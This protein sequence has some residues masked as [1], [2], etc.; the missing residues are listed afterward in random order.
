MNCCVECFEDINVIKL[1]ESKQILNKKCDYCDSEDVL[2]AD[3]RDLSDMFNRLFTYYKET[4]PFEHYF[5]EEE[6]VFDVGNSLWNLVQ[7]NW[8]IFGDIT[9][10]QLLYD[11][12]NINRDGKEDEYISES[13]YFSKVTDSIMHDSASSM[14]ELLSNNLKYRNRYFPKKDIDVYYS[15]DDLLRELER[16]FTNII[17]VVDKKNVFYRAR[18][19]KFKDNHEL[20]APPEDKILKSGRANPVGIR[21]LYSAIDIETAIAE[22]RPWKSALI[23]IASI[24][25]TGELK[26]VDLS[27]ISNRK[28]EVLKSFFSTDNM[29]AEL[30]ALDL[31]SSLD[32]ALSKPVYPDLSE[33]EYIPSQYLTEFIKS[34]GYDGVIFRSS[35]GPGENYVFF[36]WDNLLYEKGKLDIR[37]IDRFEVNDLKY[38]FSSKLKTKMK[39]SC[40]IDFI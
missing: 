40:T 34:L 19:G 23:T 26:L 13:T 22:V 14:W 37:I 20:N 4:T 27:K 5:P 25:P 30:E 17:T 11:I 15:H 6:D 3:I 2:V 10:E 12:V 35:L 8:E 31:L 24:K 33:L 21:V 18:I 38:N 32:L 16:L 28:E 29:V 1:I 39:K 7:E 36:E 9:K